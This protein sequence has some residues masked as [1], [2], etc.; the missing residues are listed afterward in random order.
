MGPKNVR[1]VQYLLMWVC[2]VLWKCSLCAY[3]WVN[4]RSD[5][6]L[7]EAEKVSHYGHTISEGTLACGHLLMVSCNDCPQ[8]TPTKGLPNCSASLRSGYRDPSF[9]GVPGSFPPS[10]LP[11]LESYSKDS[12]CTKHAMLY[13][14]YY[15]LH[16]FIYIH[17]HLHHDFFNNNRSW[18]LCNFYT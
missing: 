5:L 4:T 18:R 17:I 2:S 7:K 6:R 9:L 16:P 3:F 13:F 1:Y 10:W 14:I 8:T 11:S 12:M 15:I